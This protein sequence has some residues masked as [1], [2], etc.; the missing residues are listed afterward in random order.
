MIIAKAI[1]SVIAVVLMAGCDSTESV[2][3]RPDPST[4]ADSTTPSTDEQIRAT[5]TDTGAPPTSLADRSVPAGAEPEEFGPLGSTKVEIESDSGTV[6]IGGGNVP[7]AVPDTFPI[8]D[9]LVI[10]LST[11]VGDNAGFSG[12]TQLTFDELVAFYR[13]GLEDSG[14]FVTD[15]QIDGGV[16]VVLGFDGLAGRGQVA[17]SNAP[18]GQGR[19]V[20]ITFQR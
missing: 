8:P 6:Q 12:V 4:V 11:G 18:G 2:S 1:V 14:Y 9:D 5:S 15:E 19:S 17:M 7:D 10:Q 3:D 16:V 13:T 20:L